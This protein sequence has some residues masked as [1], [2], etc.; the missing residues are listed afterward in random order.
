MGKAQSQTLEAWFRRKYSLPPNDPRFLS[1]T[2]EMIEADFWMHQYADG[3]AGSEE[4]EDG[5][6]DLAAEIRRA[7]E[8]GEAAEAARAAAAATPPEDWEDLPS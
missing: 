8:E 2:V 4:F 5:D 1:A 6:F 3:K 7:E